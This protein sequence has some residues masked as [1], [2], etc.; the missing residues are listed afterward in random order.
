MEENEAS[1]L[2]TGSVQELMDTVDTYIKQ[3]AR[4]LDAPFL[5]SIESTLIAKVAVRLLLVKLIK[6]K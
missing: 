2:G 1:E 4:L 5:L 3:P 6:V